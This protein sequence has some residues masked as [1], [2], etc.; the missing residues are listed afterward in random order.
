MVVEFSNCRNGGIFFVDTLLW[1]SYEIPT[2]HLEM[3]GLLMKRFVHM[4]A[5]G[6]ILAIVREGRNIEIYDIETRQLKTNLEGHTDQV[7]GVSFS[8]DGSLLLTFPFYRR[9]PAS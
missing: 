1:G 3:T 8:N 9:G 7:M 5:Y 4:S 2:N 6:N